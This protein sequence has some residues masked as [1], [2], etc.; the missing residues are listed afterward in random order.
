MLIITKSIYC[1]NMVYYTLIHHINTIQYIIIV[2]YTLIYYIS[3]IQNVSFK[4]QHSYLKIKSPKHDFYK[5]LTKEDAIFAKC[6]I[7][8]Q[9]S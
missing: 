2:Y 4:T 3:D 6:F 1:I 9:L 7:A 5:D 8:T